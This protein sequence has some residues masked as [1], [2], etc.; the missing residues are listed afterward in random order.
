MSVRKK[1]MQRLKSK[2]MYGVKM[3]VLEKKKMN[4]RTYI[5]RTFHLGLLRVT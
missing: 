5:N 3:T 2:K 1:T 4:Y